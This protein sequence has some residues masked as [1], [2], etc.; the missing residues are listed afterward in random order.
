LIPGSELLGGLIQIGM[1]RKRIKVTGSDSKTQH[2]RG[3]WKG[4]DRASRSARRL[5]GLTM[6]RF[7]F[8]VF[9]R[10][11]KMISNRRCY[12]RMSSQPVPC[13]FEM[14]GTPGIAWVVDEAIGG[15]R[16]SGLQLRRLSLDQK[17][18]VHFDDQTV[19]GRCRSVTRNSDG[20]FSVGIY[21]DA[22]AT[23]HEHQSFLLTTFTRLNEFD[24]VCSICSRPS[25]DELEVKLLDGKSFVLHR[26]RVVE[27]TRSERLMA[28]SDE[29]NEGSELANVTAI[30]SSMAVGQE[31]MEVESVLDHEFGAQNA[32]LA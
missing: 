26:S 30:Y 20:T 10:R 9:S 7:A 27:L 21:R 15:I 13:T 31:L 6:V 32:C 24:V 8:H 1:T 16:I 29:G 3:E 12:T 23:E 22:S 2:R 14:G 4:I 25:Q 5:Q 18:T 28:L 19:V 11:A 17:I